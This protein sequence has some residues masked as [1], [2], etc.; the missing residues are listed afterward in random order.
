MYQFFKENNVLVSEFAE[1]K[2]MLLD[3]TQ[4]FHFTSVQFYNRFTL[5]QGGTAI[6][7]CSPAER[8]AMQT[9]LEKMRA[10]KGYTVERV[11]VARQ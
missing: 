8:I 1:F 11:P 2:N 10:A 9:V 7:P 3:E 5:R 4:P 6:T